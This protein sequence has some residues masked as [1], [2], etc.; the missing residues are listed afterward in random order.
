LDDFT[1]VI[2]DEVHERDI[3]IDF[4]LV[5]IKH[6]LTK[7]PRIKLILMS[8]TIST[9]LFANYFAKNNIMSVGE[10]VFYK[11]E[12]N[13]EEVF[14]NN[15]NIEEHKDH[16]KENKDPVSLAKWKNA[17]YNTE[18]NSSGWKSQENAPITDKIKVEEPIIPNNDNVLLE[19][20]A[21]VI[22]INSRTYPVKIYNLDDIISN[23]SKSNPEV[24]SY[25]ISFEKKYPKLDGSVY[26]I[27]QMMI[28]EIHNQKFIKEPCGYFYSILVFL[29]GFGE[30]LNMH[31]VLNQKMPE[32]IMNELEILHLHSNLQE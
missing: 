16:S 7:N 18:E 6:I 20:S 30:I 19:D 5:L 1:H 15:N 25:N 9:N 23:L 28:C 3:D 32:S 21:P 11:E 29:P 31:D 8:A 2:L 17:T 4:V 13:E 26:D 22:Q 24:S 10:F 12:E 27:C 14:G